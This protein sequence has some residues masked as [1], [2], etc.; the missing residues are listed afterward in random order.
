[1]ADTKKIDFISADRIADYRSGIMYS[2]R[3]GSHKLRYRIIFGLSDIIQS[4]GILITDLSQTKCPL[5]KIQIHTHFNV[6][7]QD[8]F[9]KVFALFCVNSMKNRETI[10][11][12]EISL[13]N[14]SGRK[15]IFFQNVDNKNYFQM[16]QTE[17]I[18]QQICTGS[19]A[20]D[21]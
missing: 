5:P 7:T 2:D 21:F 3:S 6:K 11:R 15:F 19:L 10:M 9:A 1:M 12:N 20:Q 13:F 8:T 14:T 17:F 18:L 4:K 16:F